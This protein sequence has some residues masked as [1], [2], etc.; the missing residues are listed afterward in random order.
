MSDQIDRQQ[1]YRKNPVSIAQV[2]TLVNKVQGT[3]KKGDK[4]KL[5]GAVVFAFGKEFN[6]VTDQ[7]D[8]MKLLEYGDPVGVVGIGGGMNGKKPKPVFVTFKGHEWAKKHAT[9]IIKQADVVVDAYVIDVGPR[10]YGVRGEEV[11]SMK[12]LLSAGGSS[13]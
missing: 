13:K 8:A 9:K 7:Q 11:A 3:L 4:P 1:W 10:R 6:F 12:G 2:V 5:T